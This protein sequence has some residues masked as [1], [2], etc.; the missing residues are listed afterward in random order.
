MGEYSV[1][2]AAGKI[3]LT[4]FAIRFYSDK[5]LIPG[6]TRDAH[7]NRQ[8]GDEAMQWLKDV[9]YLR[10]C[11]MTI[12][13]IHDYVTLSQA[14]PRTVPRRYRI[15]ERQQHLLT[16]RIMD[17]QDGQEYLTRTMAVYRDHAGWHPVG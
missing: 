12:Q 7:Q 6:V 13:A 11:G 15:L 17:L 14:G 16:H 9:K 2:E 10:L 5:G 8:Y 4:D 3:G 1:H